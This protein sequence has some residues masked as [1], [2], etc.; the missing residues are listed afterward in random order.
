MYGPVAGLRYNF[1][2]VKSYTKKIDPAY[3]PNLRP[4]FVRQDVPPKPKAHILNLQLA[5]GWKTTNTRD[6]IGNYTSPV[7]GIATVAI[8]YMR[9]YG[10]IGR[11]GGGLDFFIDGSLTEEVKDGEETKFKDLFQLGY[12]VGHELIIDQF[13]FITH[14]G[15][16]AFNNGNKGNF[17]LRFNLRINVNERFAI[18]GGLK[19]KNGG[20]ADFIEWGVHYKLMRK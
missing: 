19:T 2:P 16:Y 13:T 4:E 5:G 1:N 12:H 9:Q 8:D 3:Q 6:S 17:W 14:V 10:H 7:Y 18:Q 11:Y 20:V 15:F